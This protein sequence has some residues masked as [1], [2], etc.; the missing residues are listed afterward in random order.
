MNISI[1]LAHPN[2]DSFNHAI[3]RTVS[4][5]LTQKGH[6][7][8]MHDLY[9]EGFD[10]LLRKEEL[11]PG[12][13]IPDDV[14]LHCREIT[15]ADGIIVVHPNWWG[16]PAAILKGWIDR[17]LRQN[18]AYRFETNDQGEG[19]PVGLLR[20]R[21]AIVFNT[22]NTPSERELAV[23]G[24]PLEALWKRCIFDLCGVKT[25]HRETFSVV[26][27]STAEQRARWLR[28]AE[29]IALKAFPDYGT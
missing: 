26:I 18:V 19:V 25:V 24:D 2:P 15:Q 1:I 27:T 3:A 4:E 21:A 12:S 5:A 8:V 28:R 13:P 14:T 11:I 29:E 16:Q 9:A 23:F 10:P 17:V 20:A 6:H 7:P 22:A